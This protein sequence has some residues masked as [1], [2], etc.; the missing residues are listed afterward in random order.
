MIGLIG[1]L[2]FL[3]KLQLSAFVD[4][5][6]IYRKIQWTMNKKCNGR[7]YSIDMQFTEILMFRLRCVVTRRMRI[8]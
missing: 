4:V 5:G 2:G 3:Y 8:G 1:Y 7:A 6:R